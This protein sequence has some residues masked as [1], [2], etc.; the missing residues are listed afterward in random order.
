MKKADQEYVI[1]VILLVCLTSLTIF[2]A[3][4]YL[5][6]T[7]LLSN[8]I[9]LAIAY[10]ILLVVTVYLHSIARKNPGVYKMSPEQTVSSL[11]T[12]EQH[13]CNHCKQLQVN[14]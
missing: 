9:F 11:I 10:P 3:F 13:F 12:T 1:H 2:S 14:C 8:H 6:L 4:Y 7:D 5:K